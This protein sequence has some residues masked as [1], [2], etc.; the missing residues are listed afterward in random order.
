MSDRVDQG[1]KTLAKVLLASA[2]VG[3]LVVL[4][5]PRYR[6]SALAMWRGDL[7]ASPIWQSNRDYYPINSLAV[8][9]SR[10]TAD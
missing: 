3:L 5:H 9:A 10:E 1:S 2:A 4:L 6:E 8:E 7:T